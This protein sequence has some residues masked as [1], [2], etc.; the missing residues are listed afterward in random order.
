MDFEEIRIRLCKHCEDEELVTIII[1]KSKTDYY[2]QRRKEGTLVLG[3]GLVLILLGFVITCF[4]Y[5]ANQ[6]VTLA[7]YGLTSAGILVVMWGLYKIM[8]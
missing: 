7:M 5:H 8:G 1:S 2:N 3:I 6:S 4:N